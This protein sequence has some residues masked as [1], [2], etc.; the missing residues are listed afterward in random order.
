MVDAA[1]SISTLS[2]PSL[3]L[4]RA[5]AGIVS[6]PTASSV[7]SPT[8]CSSPR[9][10]ESLPPSNRT[11]A[12]TCSSLLNHASH[13]AHHASHVTLWE[14]RL[15]ILLYK[16]S[17]AGTEKLLPQREFGQV[18]AVWLLGANRA[19]QAIKSWGAAAGNSESRKRRK[20][21]SGRRLGAARGLHT[22]C[23]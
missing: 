22:V 13:I 5:A 6:L 4:S 15:Q 2:I 8:P 17:K 9:I 11:T 1:A 12:S 19:E 3:S 7:K 10:R 23:R 14:N 18:D 21:I 20:R 16:S